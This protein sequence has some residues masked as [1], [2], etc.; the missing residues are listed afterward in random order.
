MENNEMEVIALIFSFVAIVI[1]IVSIREAKKLNDINLQS[2]YLKSIYFDYLTNKFP[3][4]RKKLR[5]DNKS[6]L[7]DIEFLQEELIDF[8]KEL[9]FYK[10][11]DGQFYESIKMKI[12]TLE[13]FIVENE[14]CFFAEDKKYVFYSKVDELMGEIYKCLE[15]KYKNG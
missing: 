15:K 3:Q 7:K 4:A 12:Q 14:D 5:F 2:E 6:I 8:R 1:S 10:Y 11:I 9:F 13:D